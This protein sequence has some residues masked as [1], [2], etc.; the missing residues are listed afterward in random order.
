MLEMLSNFEFLRPYMFWL[1][2]PIV[3]LTLF[4]T[5]KSDLGS[6]WKK[7]CEEKFLNYLLIKNEKKAVSGKH[8]V[9]LFALLS[10]VFALAG[11]SFEKKETPALSLQNPLMIALDLSDMMNKTDVR[12]SRLSRAKIEITDLLNQSG[13]A[14]SG[15]IVYTNEPFLIS[16]LSEDPKMIINLLPAVQTDIMPVL[17]SRPDK[18][19][20]LAVER[21]KKSGFYF[22]D[23]VLFLSTINES[24]LNLLKTSAQKAFDEHIR[25][26]I[27]DMSVA[28]SEALKKVADLGGG[29]YVN[30]NTNNNKTLIN[31]LIKN[32]KKDLKE[33]KNASQTPQDNGWYFVFIPAIFVLLFFKKG[34]MIVLFCLLFCGSAKAGVLFNAN[35]EGSLY[36]SSKEYQKAAERFDDEKWKAS[37]Y[38]KAGNYQKATGLFKKQTDIESLYNMGNALAKAGDIDGAIKTY[39]KVLSQKP[40]HEDAKFNL[41]Y[42]KNLKE[43]QQNNKNQNNENKEEDNEDQNQSSPN[44]ENQ[45]QNGENQEGSENEDDESSQE[46]DS[47]Q[48]Q[49]GADNSK[50]KPD[51]SSQNENENNENNLENDTSLEKEQAPELPAKEGEAEK[52]DETVQARQQQFREIKEDT[53]GLLKAFIYEEYLKKRYNQ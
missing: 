36:F 15:L 40:D 42:L 26:N 28:P 48:E 21:L 6:A 27:Y 29:V 9:L 33:G 46:N 19:V 5:P 20:D 18:A 12:P 16:P 49:T 52:Y 45:D 50:D 7:V 39:E 14:P 23:V 25:L 47:S 3:F 44:D 24:E 30:I 11:P 22:G 43:N 35:Q 41:E 17:G 2:L 38:Y 10:A 53:G 4:F 13:A 32:A 51:D 34:V 31:A 8:L 1:I 37:A